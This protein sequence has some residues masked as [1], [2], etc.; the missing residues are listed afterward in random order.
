[1]AE[2]YAGG[3]K[4]NLELVPMGLAYTYRQY[5]SGCDA[6]AYLDALAQA[7]RLGIEPAIRRNRWPARGHRF[8]AG[9][10]C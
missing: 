10:R 8:D 4:V 9:L 6:N 2:V 3:R 5:L 1:M 7:D